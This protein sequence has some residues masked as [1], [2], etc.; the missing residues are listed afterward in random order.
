M[1]TLAAQTLQD[2]PRNLVVKLTGTMD[3]TN[4]SAALAIDVSSYDPAPT[5]VRI[6]KI[7]WVMTDAVEAQLFWDATTDVLI[8]NLS[9]Q[10]IHHFRDIGG[11]QNN[12][13]SGVTGDILITSTGAAVG[14]YMTITLYMV[15]SD[16]Q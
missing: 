5:K 7:E 11:L 9:D 1:S 8:T 4:F 14:A 10:G 3:A 13:G 16:T 2:G 6:D 15:K 12:A